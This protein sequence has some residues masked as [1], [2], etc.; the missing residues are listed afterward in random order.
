MN[1][2]L[3]GDAGRYYYQAFMS[4]LNEET[5][6][7]EEIHS[8]VAF[9]DK[10]GQTI[11]GTTLNSDWME[12]PASPSSLGS[13]KLVA[14][15]ATMGG[16]DTRNYS[17]LYDPEYYAATWVAFNYCKAHRGSG[18]LSSW[19]QN[20]QI[21]D[22]LEVDV[23]SAYQSGY[24]RGHQI[25]NALRNGVSSMQKQTYYF[26]NSTPQLGDFNQG[27]WQ[28]LETAE[29]KII[30]N[31]SASATDTLYIV[32]GPVYQTVNGNES[33]ST[34]TQSGKRVPVANYYYRVILKVRRN[35]SGT[36]TAASAIGFWMPHS[37]SIADDDY[38]NYACS[39]SS[40]EEKTGFTFFA[41]L[42]SS[43]S[44]SAKANTS[45]TTFKNFSF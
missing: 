14:M 3:P 43:V 20:P 15:R 45:W 13:R 42:P 21:D 8:D 36:V 29:R 4:V 37:N 44:S 19:T 24:D 34:I 1:V 33:Y 7:F 38:T 28:D 18:S 41:N 23:S 30:D 16:K 26:T 17:I 12:L 31:N 22:N 32:T 27:I 11:S 25:P 2:T 9:F 5:G 6:I 10:P 40:I 39:V 35:T